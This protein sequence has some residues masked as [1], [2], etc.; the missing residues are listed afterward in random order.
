MP[1]YQYA[2]LNDN[3]QDIRLLKLLPGSF[4]E[5]VRFALSHIPFVPP[6]E[7]ALQRLSAKELDDTLPSGW[8]VLETYKRRFIFNCS[9]TGETSW[10]HPDPKFRNTQC[11]VSVEDAFRCFQPSYEALSYTWGS[12]QEPRT[13]YIETAASLA[14]TGD[15]F[16]TLLIS[17]NLHLALRH[18]RYAQKSRTLWVDAVCINQNDDRER[19][20]QV[21]RMGDIYQFATRVLV[22]LGPEAN[23]SGV[24]LS[25]L[26][27][28]GAQSEETVQGLR[29]RSPKSTEPDWIHSWSK[30]PYSVREWCAIRDLAL[31]PWFERQWV[32]QEIQL[33]NSRATLQCG[34]DE[35]PWSLFRRAMIC[36]RNKEGIPLRDLRERLDMIFSLAQ[37]RRQASLRRLLESC[38]ELKCSDPRDKVYGLLGLVSP[39][40]SSKILPDYSLSTETVHKD[41]FMLHLSHVQR[42]E[43]LPYCHLGERRMK[44]PS[45]VPDFSAQRTMRTLVQFASGISRSEATYITPNILEV[46]GV[47]CAILRHVSQPL[48]GLEDSGATLSVIRTWEREN[49]QQGSYINSGESLADAFVSTLRLNLLKE[50]FPSF[51][52][53]TLQEWRQTY[54]SKYSISASS[55]N[56]RADDYTK[57][58]EDFY[59]CKGRTFVI[60]EEGY[61]GLCPVGAYPGRLLPKKSYLTV[62][63]LS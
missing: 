32:F 40:V 6:N 53:P 9:E 27:Y 16:A 54:T 33:A 4:D 20:A 29:I 56:L 39:S 37:D 48:H 62:V 14:F 7:A 10:L 34:Y 8:T 3:E 43:L 52:I 24:A 55:Q 60:S 59:W 18:L 22:W 47:Q 44:G 45:W 51:G 26:Q 11:T 49:L 41:A 17:Q 35:I 15:S 58:E 23:E 21:R 31:R 63:S 50:R 28:L 13:A 42:L 1:P 36:L 38:W 19:S 25:L 5:P 30:L 57:I 46:S 2:Q 61:I 12:I